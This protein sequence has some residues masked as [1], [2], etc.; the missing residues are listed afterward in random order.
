MLEMLIGAGIFAAGVA[1]GRFLPN[2]RRS[3]EPKPQ[4]SCGHAVSFHGP[5]GHCS[6]MVDVTKWENGRWLGNMREQCTCQR[7]TGPQP[8][9]AFYAP[10]I[11]D[12]T[13]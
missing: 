7:Y 11:S 9:P 6:A 1:A 3:N 13:R 4:C 8:L 2:R 12:D 10:E 5:D